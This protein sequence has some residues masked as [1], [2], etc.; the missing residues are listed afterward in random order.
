MNGDDRLLSKRTVSPWPPISRSPVQ[1][2]HSF[3]APVTPKLRVPNVRIFALSLFFFSF[4]SLPQSVSSPGLPPPPRALSFQSM[5]G[6]TA[7]TCKKGARW[8]LGIGVLRRHRITGGKHRINWI[9]M[10]EPDI[11]IAM[12][13]S[14]TTRGPSLQYFVNAN[15]TLLSPVIIFSRYLWR[16][17]VT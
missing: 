1:P 8:H 4:R 6:E 16:K 3:K 17:K 7:S 12:S 10:T 9:S 2:K 14:C 15:T 5:P 11:R 13:V